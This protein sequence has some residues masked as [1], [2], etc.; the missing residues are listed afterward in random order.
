LNKQDGVQ[1]LEGRI[2]PLLLGEGCQ[3]H[4]IEMKPGMYCEEHPHLAVEFARRAGGE[5]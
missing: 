4:F 2:G 1:T 3:C 5:V